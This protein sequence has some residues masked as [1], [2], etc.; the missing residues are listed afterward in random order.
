MII[1]SQTFFKEENGNKKYICDIIK[2]HDLYKKENFWEEI[3]VHKIEE[4]FKL[5][6]KLIQQD[7]KK[8]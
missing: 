1:L 3:V 2:S 6:N 4:E 5:K 8:F 7:L